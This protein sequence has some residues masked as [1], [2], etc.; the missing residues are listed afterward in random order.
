MKKIIFYLFLLFSSFIIA[1]PPN[2]RLKNITFNQKVKKVKG[3]QLVLKRVISDSRC[4]EGV[5]CIWA[6]ECQI[7]VAIYKNRKLISTE[8]I[9]LSPKLKSENL[10]WF[11]EFYSNQ[12]IFEISLFPY[13]K[14]E[15]IINSKD[16]Y[17]KVL[18]K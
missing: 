1:Q 7:E 4:P 2:L 3:K 17:I 18:Y 11:Q 8:S 12:N 15:E 6:G 5:N 13:P 16:Y 9:L 14:S 10:S